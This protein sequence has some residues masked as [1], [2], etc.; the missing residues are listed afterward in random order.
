[1]ESICRN[2]STWSVAGGRT[3]WGTRVAA[4]SSSK[5]L[6]FFFESSASVKTKSASSKPTQELKGNQSVCDGT[7]GGS[8]VAS[9]VRNSPSLLHRV[10][11]GVQESSSVS[12]G[13]AVRNVRTSKKRVVVLMILGNGNIKPWVVFVDSVV[14]TLEA[15]SISEP[16]VALGTRNHW[17]SERNSRVSDGICSG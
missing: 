3:S 2:R 1:M 6:I 10:A 9:A 14:M 5:R 11:I 13:N 16:A 4:Q 12:Q 17:N 15:T 7:A 8:G